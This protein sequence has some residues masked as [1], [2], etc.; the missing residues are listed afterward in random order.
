MS[1]LAAMTKEQEM[2]TKYEDGPVAGFVGYTLGDGWVDFYAED[3][4]VCRWDAATETVTA[5]VTRQ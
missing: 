2:M 5:T 3:G 4:G 1:E